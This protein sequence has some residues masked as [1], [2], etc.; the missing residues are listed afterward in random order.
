M[1][2]I[3]QESTIKFLPNLIY[4]YTHILN[5]R[6]ETG[7]V[8]SIPY[9]SS[10]STTLEDLRRVL[11]EFDFFCIH[12]P[13]YSR[14]LVSRDRNITRPTEGEIKFDGFAISANPEIS[15][16]EQL[17]KIFIELGYAAQSVELDFH[18]TLSFIKSILDSDLEDADIDIIPQVAKCLAFANNLEQICEI[19]EVLFSDAIQSDR[20]PG[21]EDA[22]IKR[23]NEL[24]LTN[25]ELLEALTIFTS[26]VIRAALQQAVSKAS[27]NLIENA[28]KSVPINGAGETVSLASDNSAMTVKLKLLKRHTFELYIPREIKPIK[29]S[30][31]N[32]FENSRTSEVSKYARELAFQL[33][34]QLPNCKVHYIEETGKIELSRN[35]LI[36]F[37]AE[38][39]QDLPWNEL[40]FDEFLTSVTSKQSLIP[41]LKEYTEP[42]LCLT[43]ESRIVQTFAIFS[44]IASRVFPQPSRSGSNTPGG[45]PRGRTSSRATL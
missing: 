17:V 31:Y 40:T 33:Q 10:Q 26:P 8:T 35:N 3:P 30:I 38:V 12:Q 32:I 20:I 42:T 19:A 45:K 11:E 29:I 41:E 27:V 37:T 15:F 1:M 18:T 34:M 44:E 13:E 4:A 43:D 9:F 5:V 39:P 22:L 36:F 7:G 21:F 24:N 23:M 6:N 28:D 2:P 14:L 25:A 16:H